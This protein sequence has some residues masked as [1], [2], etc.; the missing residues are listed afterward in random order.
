[1]HR[2]PSSLLSI[3]SIVASMTSVAVGNGMMLAYVP[4]V[5]TRSAA[6]DWVPGAAVTAIAF[7]GL[8]GCLMGG[9]LIRRVGHARAFSCSMALV[10]LAALMISLGVHP[11]LW[12]VA[13]G[14]YGIAA[15]MNFIITQSWLNHASENHWRGRAMALFYMAYVIGLGAGAW[16][17]GQIPVEGNLAPIVTIFFT[18]VAILPIGLTRLPT[19][20]AP[21]RVSIDIPMVWRISPVAF[22]GVLASGGLSM[23]VQGFTPIYAAANSVSQKE[24]AALMFVMQFGLLFIQY[25]MGALS[26]RTDRR[27]VLIA[28]CTL[29]IAAGIAALA[30]SFDN[31]LL[32]MLVFAMFAGAVETVYSIANAHANDRTDPADFVPLA[33]TMLVA[34]SA[35]ATLVPMLVTLLTPAFGQRTFIYATMTVALLYALFVLVRLRSRERVPPELCDSFEF[36]SAQVPNAAALAETEARAERPVRR[37]DL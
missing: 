20:P 4:F 22:I 17:F 12:V 14:L 31:L 15:N 19:P 30:V 8:I 10:I 37:P 3:A 16:L 26:D 11:L 36:K 34:W 21:A 5:L 35:S 18:A 24:V 23:L 32:L 1:M 6:P 25:P 27:I 7:G 33:S 29:V 13:R 28:T 2:S 9:S